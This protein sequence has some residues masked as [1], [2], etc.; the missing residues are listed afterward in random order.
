DLVQRAIPA[1]AL[2]NVRHRILRSARRNA[3]PIE[4]LLTGCVVALRPE[5]RQALTLRAIGVFPNS[6]KRNGK[7][8]LAR[9][10]FVDADDDAAVLFDLPLLACGRLGDLAL[11]PAGLESA[12]H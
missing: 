3:Q 11:E 7:L 5:R 4:R 10:E 6:K 9:F 1:C 8:L 2:E 12:R